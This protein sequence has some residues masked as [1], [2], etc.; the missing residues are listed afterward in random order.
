VDPCADIECPGGEVCVVDVAGDVQCAGPWTV[1]DL[2]PPPAD[3]GVSGADAGGLGL[4]IGVANDAAAA[5]DAANAL[6]QPADQ[7]AGCACRV[8]DGQA[9]RWL[10][11]PALVG[12]AVTRRRRRR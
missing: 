4:D 9:P 7:V 8:G 5:P 3:A 11:L 12:F 10:L 6:V 1:E 2:T